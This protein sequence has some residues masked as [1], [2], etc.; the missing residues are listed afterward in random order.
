MPHPSVCTVAPL[1]SLNTRSAGTW[2]P[3]PTGLIGWRHRS[4]LGRDNY[5]KTERS[6][7]LFP[8]GFP[9]TL[10][11]INERIIQDVLAFQATGRS[12]RSC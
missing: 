2:E 10:V 1:S 5:V 6:G 9:A 4:W 12:H 11:K 8:L 7:Y 3:G